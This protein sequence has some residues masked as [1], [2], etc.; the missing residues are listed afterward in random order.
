MTWM[1]LASE[2]SGADVNYYTWLGHGALSS[3]VFGLIGILLLLAGYWLFDLITPRLDVQKELSEKNTAVAI[4]VGA[5][6][7][8]IAYVVAHVVQ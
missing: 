2:V 4:V 7:L 1:L 3:I 5:L 6:L 8:G